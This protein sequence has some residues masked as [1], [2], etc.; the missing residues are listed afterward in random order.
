MATNIFRRQTNRRSRQ[1]LVALALV[2]LLSA[3]LMGQSRIAIAATPTP[4]STPHPQNSHTTN[5][6][7]DNSAALPWPVPATP[8]VPTAATAATL[9][10]AT[11]AHATDYADTHA[12]ATS[13]LS[14]MSAPVNRMTTPVAAMIAAAPTTTGGDI[15]FI[16]GYALYDVITAW[17]TNV[18][19]TFGLVY[20][21][22]DA[23]NDLATYVPLVGAIF[24]IILV[25]I[26]FSFGVRILAMAGRIV[27]GL[28][29]LVK[30]VLTLVGLWKP[31]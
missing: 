25:V 1:P 16:G 20:A 13:Q 26:I 5:F 10:A 11:P 21:Y 15:N 12:T 24:G 4:T 3:G 14:T 18:S 2:I 23:F 9:Y 19:T 27:G 28:W 30:T 6:V 22:L 8:G 29:A 31:G 17:D 7:V